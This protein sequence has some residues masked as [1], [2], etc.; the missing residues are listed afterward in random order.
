MPGTVAYNLLNPSLNEALE[1]NP[2]AKREIARSSQDNL[3]ACAGN[4]AELPDM[5]V[6]PPFTPLGQKAGEGART[7]A[8]STVTSQEESQM[9]TGATTASVLPRRPPVP[10]PRPAKAKEHN[11]PCLVDKAGMRKWSSDMLK[12]HPG[13]RATTWEQWG[14]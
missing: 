3:A 8:S 4:I 12:G 7:K 13:G 9:E 11:E 2:K 5:S 1:Q 10:S 14:N 6:P